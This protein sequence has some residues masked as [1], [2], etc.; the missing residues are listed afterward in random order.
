MWV[1]ITG[2]TELTNQPYLNRHIRQHMIGAAGMETHALL[3]AV[4]SL[5]THG[6]NPAGSHIVGGLEVGGGEGEDL[7]CKTFWMGVG[8]VQ[9]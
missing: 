6:L 9:P 4:K 8:D 2:S 3:C 1:R 5:E 7:G